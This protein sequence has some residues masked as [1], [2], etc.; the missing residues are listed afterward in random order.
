MDRKVMQDG[1]KSYEP[2]KENRREGG[3]K[4]GEEV[5]D[6]EELIAEPGQLKRVKTMMSGNMLYNEKVGVASL[7]WLQNNQ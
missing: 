5:E 3:F 1:I 4:R 2:N 7:E 6:K